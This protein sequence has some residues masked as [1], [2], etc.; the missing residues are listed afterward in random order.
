MD[1]EEKFFF[2]FVVTLFFCTAHRRHRLRPRGCLEYKPTP[3]RLRRVDAPG[4][5]TSSP[6]VL[7]GLKLRRKIVVIIHRS[8]NIR[9]FSTARLG[10]V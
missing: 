4:S 6:R 8:D 3:F 5:P 7:P 10:V 2:P 9:V 1:D